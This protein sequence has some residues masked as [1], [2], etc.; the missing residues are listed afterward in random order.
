[1]SEFCRG[2][3]I[4]WGTD[5]YCSRCSTRRGCEKRTKVF[6]HDLEVENERL[7]GLIGGII[8]I[9]GHNNSSVGSLIEIERMCC[10]VFES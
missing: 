7:K 4:I 5:E 3:G 6:L 10:K 1:M 8:H 2:C 9:C